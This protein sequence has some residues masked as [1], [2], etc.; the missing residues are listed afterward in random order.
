VPTIAFPMKEFQVPCSSSVRGGQ[1]GL[2]GSNG[3]REPEGRF[4]RVRPWLENVVNG[5]GRRSVDN[6]THQ[7]SF[8]LSMQLTIRSVTLPKLGA[9]VEN[10][11]RVLG[12]GTP[13]RA[14][15]LAGLSNGGRPE[16]AEP[17]LLTLGFSF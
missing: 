17:V 4:F 13:A 12:L 10:R 1:Q 3:T 9:V 14:L 2:F 5:R 15:R 11:T 8:T 6:I 7:L 16:L